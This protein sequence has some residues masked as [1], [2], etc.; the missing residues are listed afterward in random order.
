MRHCVDCNKEVTRKHQVDRC[1]RCLNLHLEAIRQ[2]ILLIEQVKKEYALML[3][4]VK[5]DEQTKFAIDRKW[6]II[7]SYRVGRSTTTPSSVSL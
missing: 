4:D 3:A 2:R 7:A 6:R 5:R 1:K